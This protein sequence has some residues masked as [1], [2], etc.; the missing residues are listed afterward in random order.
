MSIHLADIVLFRT[1]GG[2]NCLRRVN[3]Y[4]MLKYVGAESGVA[5]GAT[6]V[7]NIE[8]NV[9]VVATIYPLLVHVFKLLGMGDIR[10]PDNVRQGRNFYD[11]LTNAFGHMAD[12]KERMGGYRVEVVCKGFSA[13]STFDQYCHY[14]DLFTWTSLGLLQKFVSV[15]R[16]MDELD[17]CLEFCGENGVFAGRDSHPLSRR[18]RWIAT[19]LLNMFGICNPTMI[20]FLNNSGVQRACY[21]VWS[22]WLEFEESGARPDGEDIR[23]YFPQ[24]GSAVS[25]AGPV[26]TV[27]T[28][29]MSLVTTRGVYSPRRNPEVLGLGFTAEEDAV[30]LEQG[31]RLYRLG[32]NR[33]FVELRTLYPQLARY[34]TEQLR[35]RY[36]H[37]G[38]LRN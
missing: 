21:A 24:L 22:E 20:P 31:A 35:S 8:G 29:A 26:R 3:N 9:H 33:V 1:P 30:L 28:S 13:S 25:R 14:T 4:P 18:K 36:R 38:G 23:L 5:F 12:L 11:R 10:V 19:D 34:T 6:E 16:M 32:R 15:D 27:A 17:F 37:R 2:T 7:C